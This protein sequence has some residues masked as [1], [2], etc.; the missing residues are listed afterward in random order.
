MDQYY[1]FYA[2]S[3][4]SPKLLKNEELANLYLRPK[5]EKRSE[6]S[7]VIVWKPNAIHQAD[8]CKMLIDSKE[9]YYFFIIVEVSICQVDGELLKNKTAQFVLNAFKR[10]YR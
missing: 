4:V 3:G 1:K 10:I 9:Y 6:Q 7:K 5:K 8:L 2:L